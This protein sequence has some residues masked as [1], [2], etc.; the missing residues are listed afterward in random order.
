MHVNIYIPK[1]AW[2]RLFFILIIIIITNLIL[3]VSVFSSVR[4][5]TVL[6]NDQKLTWNIPAVYGLVSHREIS[7]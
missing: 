6:Q 1:K 5:I 7:Q 4:V 3:H 2:L